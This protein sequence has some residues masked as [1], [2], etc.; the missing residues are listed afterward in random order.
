[1][2]NSDALNKPGGQ[3][4]QPLALFGIVNFLIPLGQ[5]EIDP[6]WMEQMYAWCGHRIIDP[7]V[8]NGNFCKNRLFTNLNKYCETT[9]IHLPQL[10]PYGFNKTPH[11]DVKYPKMKRFPA[12]G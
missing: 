8:I 5:I 2:P 10:K 11:L 9:K 1:L 12:N 6:H 4:H 3:L 7:L